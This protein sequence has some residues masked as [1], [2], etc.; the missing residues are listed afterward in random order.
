MQSKITQKLSIGILALSLNAAIAQKPAQV[1]LTTNDGAK[2]LHRETD[3][4]WSKTPA[5]GATISVDDAKRFQTIDGFG[6]ALTGGSAQLLMKM[7]PA[8]RSNLLHELFGNGDGQIGMSY[9]RVSVGAS[10][11][12]AYVYTYD[13]MPT[14]ETD[15]E[16]KHFTLA[17]DE[18]DV[19]PV[20]K[21]I[22]TTNPRLKILASPWTAPS[23]M[24]TN[25]NVKGGALKKEYY[26]AYAQYWVKYLQGMKAHG[27]TIDA[28]TVQNEPENPKN[29]P[30][31]VMTADEE[32]EF[33]GQHL[34]PALHTAGLQTRI[35]AF[36]HNCDHPNYPETV[37]KDAKS[38]PV[39][40]GSGFHLY[41]GDISAMTAVHD[42]YPQKNIYFTEQ[43]VVAYK[44]KEPMPIARP[45]SRVVIGA[46]NNWSRNVLLWNLAADPQNGPHTNNGGCPMC[47][48]SLTLDGDKVARLV[49]H[50]TAAH[51]S[52]FV[53]PGSVRIGSTCDGTCPSEVVLRT[54]KGKYVLLVSNPDAEAREFS[55]R[56]HGKTFH[57]SLAAGAVATY[58]W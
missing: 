41:L 23:W 11:M 6:H 52:K 38:G 15:P 3:L 33:I 44:T 14:G 37:L 21:E 17:E 20:L 39:A 35:I 24:K 4:K 16:L 9:L 12:N 25:E 26:P 32:A 31:L 58:V 50:Y 47:S 22:L 7:T 34:G 57:T 53:P 55:V 19:I 36:D 8:A 56:F 42:A 51:A 29:T 18:K 43:M 49:A 1:W 5:T 10:D 54:P 45:F 28:L 13:D 40:D 30:S 2:L 48:G 27:I 46:L